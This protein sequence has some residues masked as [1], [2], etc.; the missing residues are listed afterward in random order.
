MENIKSGD[1]VLHPRHGNTTLTVMNLLGLKATCGYTNE[2]DKFI[3]NEYPISE[4]IKVTD[5]ETDGKHHG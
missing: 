4:L 3:E 5:G 2:N 1:T